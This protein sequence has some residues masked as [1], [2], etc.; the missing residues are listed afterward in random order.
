MY[1]SPNC[2]MHLGRKLYNPN[3]PLC[4][5]MDRRKKEKGER[6]GRET[7]RKKGETQREG[8]ETEREG[9]KYVILCT[10]SCDGE[11]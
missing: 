8:R 9:R 3:S 10:L 6:G 1:D 2:L 5:Q 4:E 11:E 7:E